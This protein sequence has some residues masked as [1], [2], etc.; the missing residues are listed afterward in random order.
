MSV[1]VNTADHKEDLVSDEWGVEEKK[2]RRGDEGQASLILFV[3]VISNDE[4]TDHVT[5][6]RPI[7]E[8]TT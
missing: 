2:W 1:L 8:K 4:V 3:F 7:T 6:S 5:S